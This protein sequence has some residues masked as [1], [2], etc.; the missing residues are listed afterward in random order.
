M[1]L[2]IAT[3]EDVTALRVLINT[4]A[5]GLREGFYSAAQIEA[6][7]L[8]TFG[9]DEQLIADRTY[10]LIE[11]DGQIVAAGGW[12]LRAKLYGAV[13]T[14]DITPTRLDP[15]VDAARIRAFFVAPDAARQG[16]GSALLARCEAEARQ[17]GFARTVLLGTLPGV[18]FYRA[19]GY[20]AT[21]EVVKQVAPEVSMSFVTMEKSL[22][23]A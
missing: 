8:G 10:W 7:L 11:R 22:P 6:A 12:S 2:R 5:R 20:L 9:V 14:D 13:P 23:S 21:G 4:S 3:P 16:L 15:T 19:R 17:F 18:P 1:G